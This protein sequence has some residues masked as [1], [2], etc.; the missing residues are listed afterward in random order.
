MG[1]DIP[2]AISQ[3]WLEERYG[4]AAAQ[5]IFEEILRAEHVA[6]DV[7]TNNKDTKTPEAA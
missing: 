2:M 1:T 5:G 4:V 7:G 3:E 6:N